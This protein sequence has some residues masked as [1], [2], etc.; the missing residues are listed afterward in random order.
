MKILPLVSCAALV[1]LS[2]CA[3][4]IVESA[5]EVGL[6]AVQESAIMNEICPI[7]GTEVDPELS[8]AY[9]EARVAFC[10][11]GCVK[12]WG[13]MSEEERAAAMAE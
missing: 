9:G 1:L 3:Q 11:G 12:K 5:P 4:P 6:A 13:R 2:A 7:M 8:L 10:C